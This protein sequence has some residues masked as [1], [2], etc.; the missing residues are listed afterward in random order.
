MVNGL[1]FITVLLVA[2]VSSANSSDPKEMIR[3]Q[4]QATVAEIKK[5]MA[6]SKTIKELQ[7]DEKTKEAF[8]TCQL[9][10]DWA[11]ED[12]ERS[13]EKLG[14]VSMSKIKDILLTLQVWLSGVFT[15]QQTCIDSYAEM[16]GAAA[17]KMTSI[18]TKSQNLT[19][20]GLAIL[21]GLSAITKDLDLSGLDAFG[22]K[23]R[24]LS[25]EFPEWMS[26]SDRRLLEAA[27][28]AA[29]APPKAADAA[30]AAPPKA[31]DAA[32]AAPPKAAD[33]AAAAPPKETD[34]AAAAPPKETDAAAAAPPKEA[35]AAAGA[36][37]AG[38]AAGAPQE[39]AAGGAPQAGAAAAGD[40]KPDFIVAKDGSGKYDSVG[41]ALAEI[42][43]KNTKRVVIMIKA[44]TYDERIDIPKGMANIMLIGEGPTKTIITGS[45]SVE[46]TL[47]RPTTFFTATVSTSG[48]GFIAKDI[49]FENSIGPEG[50][51]AVA[52]R[53]SG[54]MSAFYNCQFNGYQDTLYSHEGR[55]FYRDCFISGTVD[56]IFGSA[57]ALF[58]NC[59]LVVRKPMGNQ[60]CI[61]VAQGKKA[62]ESVS[63]FVFQNCTISGDKDYIPVKDKNK[64]YLNRP[65]RAFATVVIMQSQID[66]IIQPLGYIPMD[67][68][69]GLNDGYFAE[70]GNR[71]PGSNTENRAKWP[72]I[73]KIDGTEAKKFTPGPFLESETW[74]PS[75]GIPCIPDMIPGL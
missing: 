42:P 8:K 9:M 23:R 55:H 48:I 39:G 65:W 34:A 69:K 28:A 60:A 1:L 50:H 61:V 51:Q 3:S 53:V 74:V 56:F 7:S 75:T 24:L 72:S 18:L 40:F 15:S 47:P 54:D 33:A 10:F 32:A 71:G 38:A 14:E 70:F 12:L 59:Q 25:G 73:K 49:A 27:D 4:F 22:F 67:G 36:P 58:Q 21:D 35:G 46:K 16:D 37:K 44:G 20:H 31:A 29:A 41:K 17:D 57:R 68:D 45:V 64:S 5:V 13:F 63:G 62:Q 30:A 11:I 2:V 26:D 66:D 52:L 43:A 6:N 19:K